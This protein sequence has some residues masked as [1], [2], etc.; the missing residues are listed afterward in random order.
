[1]ELSEEE[2]PKYAKVSRAKKKAWPVGANGLRKKRIV[3]S[4]QYT[5]DKGF[6]GKS[7]CYYKCHPYL[8]DWIKHN[9]F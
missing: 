7:S 3:K 4:R 6:M 9:R 5:D 1:M 2:A 8:T